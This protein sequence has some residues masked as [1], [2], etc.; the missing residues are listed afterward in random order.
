MRRAAPGVGYKACPVKLFRGRPAGRAAP[1]PRT[2]ARPSRPPA[3]RSLPDP[4]RPPDARGTWEEA[5]LVNIDIT[6]LVK[7]Q[8]GS[9]TPPWKK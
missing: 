1:D 3:P 6:E 7:R 8:L 9:T 5:A 4:A 2:P